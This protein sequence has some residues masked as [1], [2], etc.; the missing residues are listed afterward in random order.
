MGVCVCVVSLCVLCIVFAVCG[1]SE[2]CVRCACVVHIC[3]AV[4]VCD[5]NA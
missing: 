3:L 4:C 5:A 1:V 2:A